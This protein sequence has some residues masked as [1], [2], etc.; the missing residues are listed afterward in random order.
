MV[1][2]ELSDAIRQL[3]SVLN[4]KIERIIHVNKRPFW[5]PI[6]DSAPRNFEVSD[7]AEVGSLEGSKKFNFFSWLGNGLL[8]K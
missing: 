3:E 8:N 1:N 4:K 2:N 5:G 6:N 7:A